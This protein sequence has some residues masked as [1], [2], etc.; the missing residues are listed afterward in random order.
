[1]PNALTLASDRTLLTSGSTRRARPI[2]NSESPPAIWQ[3][4]GVLGRS[5]SGGDAARE[6]RSLL[7]TGE[8]IDARAHPA[9]R[10]RDVEVSLV[11]R[12]QLERREERDCLFAR[13]VA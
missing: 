9:H 6:L 7:G 4:T 1:M 3:P 12:L 2:T 13:H 11:V 5:G 8:P 10:E